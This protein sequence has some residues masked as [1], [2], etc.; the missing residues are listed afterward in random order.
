LKLWIE[1]KSFDRSKKIHS[2]TAIFDQLNIREITVNKITSYY[3][4]AYRSLHE[5]CCDAVRKQPLIQF[6]K[7]MTDREK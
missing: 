2:I 3:E 7:S 5:V 1:R 4:C 6:V